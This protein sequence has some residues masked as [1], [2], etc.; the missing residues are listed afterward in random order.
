MIKVDIKNQTRQTF[1][2]GGSTI[3][4]DLSKGM[5]TLFCIMGTVIISVLIKRS[6]P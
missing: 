3:L 2:D 6:N 5:I 4:S 1:V